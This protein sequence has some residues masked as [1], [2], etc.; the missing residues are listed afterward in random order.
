M[1]GAQINGIDV[2]QQLTAAIAQAGGHNLDSLT[3]G[4]QVDRVYSCSSGNDTF[5]VLEGRP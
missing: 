5:L 1:T 2:K 4:Y 3:I